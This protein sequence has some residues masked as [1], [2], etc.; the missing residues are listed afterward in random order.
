MVEV[1]DFPRIILFFSIGIIFFI[2]A[3]VLVRMP[4]TNSNTTLQK[5]A[6]INIFMGLFLCSASIARVLFAYF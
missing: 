2:E 5:L 3:I 1:I 4:I 6:G